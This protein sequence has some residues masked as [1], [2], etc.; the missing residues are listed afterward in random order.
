MPNSNFRTELGPL[1]ESLFRNEAPRG[2]VCMVTALM[3]SVA[4]RCV[5]GGAFAWGRVA[6]PLNCARETGLYKND[7]RKKMYR[8]PIFE[9]R[10]LFK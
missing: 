8:L 10:L 1:W 6:G 5:G 7:R 2:G 9:L 3:T 4:I